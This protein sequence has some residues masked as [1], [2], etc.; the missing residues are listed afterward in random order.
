MNCAT[1]LLIVS[2][3]N[4]AKKSNQMFLLTMV[5]GHVQIASEPHV[6]RQSHNFS[7]EADL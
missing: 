1:V 4:E 3:D 7:V 5:K 2:S 6:L